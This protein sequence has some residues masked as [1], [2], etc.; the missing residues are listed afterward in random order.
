MPNDQAAFRAL[1]AEILDRAERD[2]AGLAEYRALLRRQVPFWKRM[3]FAAYLLRDL[4]PSARGRGGRGGRN[5]PLPAAARG[6]PAPAAKSAGGKGGPKGPDRV[7]RAERLA[8]KPDTGA[9]SEAQADEGRRPPLPEAEAVRLFVGTGRNRR[10]YARDLFAL[11]VN[12]AG[13]A[14]DDV[15]EIR[16]LDNFSFVQVRREAGEAVIA[17]LNGFSFR[18]RNLAVSFAKPRKEGAGQGEDGERGAGADAAPEARSNA[19]RRPAAERSIE[20][21]AVDAADADQDFH[22]DGYPADALDDEPGTGGAPVWPED[23]DIN[24]DESVD[25]DEAENPDDL[26]EETKDR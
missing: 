23:N 5:G 10:T 2:S 19:S 20:R 11:I 9:R 8:A 14:R 13:V 18:G 16:V 4:N 15:G 25:S 3:N 21:A 17:A 6:A 24:L 7:S 1:I 12:E 26:D 22:D